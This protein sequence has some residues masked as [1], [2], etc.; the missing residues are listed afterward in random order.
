MLRM[1]AGSPVIADR[2]EGVNLAN[3]TGA[4]S[5]VCA[6]GWGIAAWATWHTWHVQ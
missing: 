2:S 4:W 6:A 1:F 3:R 5:S